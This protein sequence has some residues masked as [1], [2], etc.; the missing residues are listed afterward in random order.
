MAARNNGRGLG[1]KGKTAGSRGHPLNPVSRLGVG[2]ARLTI[3]AAT[4]ALAACA[5]TPKVEYTPIYCLTQQQFDQ[6]KAQEP[7]KIKAQLTGK[8]DHDIGIIA[9]SAIR[10]RAYGD[11][12]LTVL[13]GCVEKP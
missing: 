5:G 10:L 2:S 8:A 12:L 6:L 13:G 11:G 4:L 1:P 9:G 3:L 7:P